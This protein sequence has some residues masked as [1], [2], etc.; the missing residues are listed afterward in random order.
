[1]QAEHRSAL[2]SVMRLM[3]IS[4]RKKKDEEELYQPKFI[5]AYKMGEDDE[6]EED[7]QPVFLKKLRTV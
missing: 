6:D 5:N 4:A 2:E 7:Y 3:A 1:M